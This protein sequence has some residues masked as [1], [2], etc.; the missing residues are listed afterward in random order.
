MLSALLLTLGGV[1]GH[2]YYVRFV[3]AQRIKDLGKE[4][5]VVRDLMREAQK[6]QF[7]EKTTGRTTFQR[8]MKQYNERISKIRQLRTKLR[9]KRVRL[10]ESGRVVK[11]LE[12]ERKEL[13][14]LLKALQTDYFKEGKISKKEYKEQL[15]AYNERLAEIE[16]E[17]LTLETKASH[18]GKRYIGKEENT[19]KADSAIKDSVSKGTNTKKGKK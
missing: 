14:E 6:K 12:G 4:E 16:D 5:E 7:K 1:A 11:D 18:R 15:K 3:L 17:E 10:I 2:Q 9:H 13:V 19:K 8:N